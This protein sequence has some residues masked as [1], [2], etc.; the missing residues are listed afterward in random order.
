[1]KK[2]MN[3]I[4]SGVSS[5]SDSVEKKL[6]ELGID[7]SALHTST[8]DTGTVFELTKP[9]TY[10]VVSSNDTLTMNEQELT[11][12]DFQR[13]VNIMT[14]EAGYSA[15]ANSE[16]FGIAS[17][18]LNEYEHVGFYDYGIYSKNTFSEFLNGFY[19]ANSN[20]STGGLNIA[21]GISYTD[22]EWRQAEEI[23]K[24]VLDG[25]R[26]FGSETCYWVGNSSGKYAGRVTGFSTCEKGTVD[27]TGGVK[28]IDY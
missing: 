27:T 26:A 12:N 11:E 25:N 10:T 28:G 15:N 19:K 16:M 14:H 2:T 17:V 6:E 20:L 4:A 5:K 1:M 9:K 24:F 21:S 8:T 13:I 18:V 7:L 22:A 23:L 3:D